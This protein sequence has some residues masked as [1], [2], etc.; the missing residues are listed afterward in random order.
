MK[1]KE[2]CFH[3]QGFSNLFLDQRNTVHKA[4]QS[5]SMRVIFTSLDE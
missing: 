2:W 4:R 3:Y 5:N 1:K